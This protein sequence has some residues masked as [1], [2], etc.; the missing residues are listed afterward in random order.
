[1]PG[2]QT[3]TVRITCVRLDASHAAYEMEI[4]DPTAS[5]DQ[6]SRLHALAAKV[7]LEGLH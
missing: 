2:S 1:M 4:P 7:R 3:L 5:A 6:V